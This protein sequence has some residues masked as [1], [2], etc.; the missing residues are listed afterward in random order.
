MSLSRRSFALLLALT[1]GFG[2]RSVTRVLARNELLGR[3]PE[4]FLRLSPEAWRE[5]YRLTKRAVESLSGDPKA[6]IARVG[7]IEKRL[8]GLGVSL[9]TAADAHYPAMVEEMDPDPPGVL[10]LYG[11]ARL[12][13]ARTFCVLASRSTLPADLELIER[14][15]EEAVLE[16]E[17]L[18][19]GHDR[20]EYQ[21][22]AVVPSAGALPAS[23]A[24]TAASS[25]SS[26]TTSATKPS[27]PPASG[28]TNSTPAPTWSSPLS[29]PK[30]TSS[31]STTK[32]AIGWSPASPAASTSSTST[33][34]ATW[35]PSCAWPSKQNAG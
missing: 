18:V 26:A 31:G 21:R 20:P 19:T 2:G 33:P 35:K 32:S 15:T 9:I 3:A 6:L 27:A 23:S 13:E 10:F 12:L 5:E 14:L 22:S 11:N 7:E 29:A 34:A 24:S 8:Y 16:G 28:A 25:K 30:P 4:D 17:V 1:P